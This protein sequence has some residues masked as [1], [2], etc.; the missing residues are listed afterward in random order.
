MSVSPFSMGDI[1]LAA[2]KVLL[3]ARQQAEQL[4]AAAQAEGEVLKAAAKAQGMT[5]GR[6][7]GLSQG[8]E[9]GKTSGEQQALNETR[10]ALQEAMAALNLATAELNARR[11]EFNARALQD[12]VQLAIAIAGRITR[13]QGLLN[14]AILIA[15]LEQAIKLVVQQSDIRVQINP[16]QRVALEA[17]LPRL[18]LKLPALAHVEIVED[19]GV[20]PGGCRILTRHGMVDADLSTQ[21][22]QIAMEL[23]PAGQ[24][25]SP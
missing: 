16:A 6:Q 5:Q 12:V 17:A 21:L 14:P 23:L 20:L 10:T 19:A 25:G 11:S 24:E 9:E 15:N 3:R 4:L 1:E 8:L 2:K 13:R 7:E 18:A 22:E